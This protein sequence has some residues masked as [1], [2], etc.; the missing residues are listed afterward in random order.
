[1]K[2]LK[3]S[4]ESVECLKLSIHKKHFVLAFLHL[5][6]IPIEYPIDGLK[7][8][9]QKHKK[10]Y[11]ISVSLIVVMCG[12]YLATLSPSFIPHAIWDSA[13]Y[14]IH[15]LGLAPIVKHVFAWIKVEV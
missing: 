8:I 7:T 9:K 4:V 14:A 12:G 13:A 2:I 10:V 15:G 6:A 5:L 3:S 1:M 11:H